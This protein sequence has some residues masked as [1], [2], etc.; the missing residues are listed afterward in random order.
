MYI[1]WSIYS[2]VYSLYYRLSNT[3]ICHVSLQ[4]EYPKYTPL[5]ATILEGLVSRSN[6]KDK[7]HHDEEVL[8]WFEANVLI[9]ILLTSSLS[10]F[11]SFCHI[12]IFVC[13]C[14]KNLNSIRV[15]LWSFGVSLLYWI[16]IF[17]VCVT[18]I[19]K[20]KL[21]NHTVNSFC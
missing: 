3:G 16:R 7:L 8:F 1:F 5:L 12:Y 19:N 14:I 2:V 15:D 6:V 10:D 20:L 17:C 9:F 4:S 11:L 18:V 21:E 13:L